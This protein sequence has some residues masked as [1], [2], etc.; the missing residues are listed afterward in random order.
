M[1]QQLTLKDYLNS[2]P[3]V[4]SART[5]L[6][7]AKAA[8]AEATR[9]LSG[10]ANA[11]QDVRNQLKNARDLAQDKVN[12]IS[13]VVKEAE[14][15]A[16][17]Y[18]KK[19]YQKVSTDVYRNTVKKLETAKKGAR[20]PEA[21]A[22]IQ[23]S[24]DS[25]NEAIANP[26]PYQEPIV[27]TPAKGV[28]GA[29]TGT[30][31]QQG[32]TQE[33][34]FVQDINNDIVTAGQYVAQ[35][36]D[37]NGRKVLAAEL[38][39]VYGLKIPVTGVYSPELKNAY[40]KML[41]D[42][43]VRSIDFGRNIATEEFLR[44]AANEGTYKG[45]D[46]GPKIG[47]TISPRANATAYINAAFKQVGLNRE[48]TAEEL[49]SLTKVLN[50][51]E[52]RF[53]TTISGGVKKDLLGDRTQFIANL[54]KTGKYTDPNTGKPIKGLTKD[55]KKAAKIVGGLQKTA[56]TLKAD[57]RSLNVQ[58]LQGTA[59]ANGISLSPQQLQQYALDIQNGKD[60]KVIQSQIRSLAG[61]GMPDTV[62]KLLAEGTD[63][64]TIYTPYKQAMAATLEINPS[65]I[66]LSDPILRNAIGPNGEMSLYEYQR[67][68]RKDPRWQYTNNAR[69]DVSTAAL[70][71]LRDFGFQG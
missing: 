59:N 54:I 26:K 19:N 34:D 43:L 28:Q 31:V 32:Q 46:G 51:A 8:L 6:D 50:D 57:T 37:D 69:E 25:L 53:R 33:P 60:I 55:V 4:T 70:Q 1:V 71:V 16:T 24:I 18:F 15:T 48:A 45:K 42:R 63:L 44:V 41:T 68:L 21:A 52:S 47:T 13:Q 38:N 64:D 66:S 5:K 29:A 12:Q 11:S 30:G 62:R 36:L 7:E 67:S 14:T 35:D 61:L 17:T 10:A 39:K 65:T 22:D 2:E 40:V 58:A 49:D 20:T 56:E 3:N 9:T 23:A 27:Q